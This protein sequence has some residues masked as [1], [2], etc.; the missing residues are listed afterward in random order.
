MMD[1]KKKKNIYITSKE[2]MYE[3]NMRDIHS[4]D[5][6]YADPWPES[7]PIESKTKSLKSGVL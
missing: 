1:N 3:G 2:C 6:W 5:W 4:M 7:I